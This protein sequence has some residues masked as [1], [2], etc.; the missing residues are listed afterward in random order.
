VR[1]R[2]ATSNA[3]GLFRVTMSVGSTLAVLLVGVVLSVAA[4]GAGRFADASSTIAIARP[5]GVGTTVHF[6]A[7]G[8]CPSVALVRRATDVNNSGTGLREQLL[9][10]GA[11]FGRICRYGERGGSGPFV[12]LRA[13]ALSGRAVLD[14]QR[15]IDLLKTGKSTGIYACPAALRSV[16]LLA[17]G[18]AHRP[19]VDLW[20]NDTGCRTLDNGYVK[21]SDVVNVVDFTRFANLVSNLAPEGAA[22]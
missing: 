4:P 18:Y 5:A 15:V 19:A 17:F 8:P 13:K 16:T 10:P 6:P 20:Y 7:Q 11:L 14:F 21:A 9:P 1:R 3:G 22:S 2:T 12:L